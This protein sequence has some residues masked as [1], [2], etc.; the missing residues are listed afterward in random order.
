MFLL[1]QNYGCEFWTF[2]DPGFNFF[3]FFIISESFE[4]QITL[5][6]NNYPHPFHL[7]GL[8][9]EGKN[10]V[11]KPVNQENTSYIGCFDV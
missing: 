3:F 9:I 4:F 6:L 7:P 8:V 2:E 1:V 11:T 5:T 10:S